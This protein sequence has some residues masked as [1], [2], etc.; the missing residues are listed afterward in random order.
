MADPQDVREQYRTTQNLDARIRLHQRFSMNAY[1]WL[2]WV[3][4]QLELPPDAWVLEVGC[5]TGQLWT[6]NRD[7]VPPGWHIVL[8]D[9]S[10]GMAQQ[11]R[12]AC[13][14]YTDLRGGAAADAGASVAS[15]DGVRLEARRSRVIP[16][17][18]TLGGVAWQE[19]ADLVAAAG[20]GTASP[21]DV[22]RAYEQSAL[23]VLAWDEG[24]LVGAARAI[25]DGIYHAMLCD[26]MVLPTHQGRGIG[27][28]LVQ[29]ILAELGGIKLLTTAAFGKE[30]FYHRLGFRR[31]KTALAINYGSWW[32]EPEG[33]AAGSS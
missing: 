3:F 20:L 16:Y 28:E 7:R 4:D 23:C 9:R 13:G 14:A 10:P 6:E 21:D 5:G 29:R 32:Y 19:L 11:T 18:H 24:R 1:G 30:E 15:D 31:H 33:E 8:T 17:T 12:A 22:R 26:V 25:S 2:P 27:R